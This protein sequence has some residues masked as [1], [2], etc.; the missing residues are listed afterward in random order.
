MHYIQ[1]S[2]V[3][4]EICTDGQCMNAGLRQWLMYECRNAAVLEWLKFCTQ[5][6]FPSQLSTNKNLMRCWCHC[7]RIEFSKA[8]VKN[9]S[10]WQRINCLFWLCSISSLAWW[11]ACV[12]GGTL[13]VTVQRR[14]SACCSIILLHSA[15]SSSKLPP[16]NFSMSDMISPWFVAIATWLNAQQMHYVWDYKC[17]SDLEVLKNGTQNFFLI[18]GKRFNI[19]KHAEFL[20]PDSCATTNALAHKATTLPMKF[21]PKVIVLMQERSSAWMQQI[22]HTMLASISLVFGINMFSVLFITKMCECRNAGW[23]LYL[24]VIWQTVA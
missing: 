17:S 1:S 5:C 2:K 9:S 22:L 4:Y 7:R 21:A 24:N 11:F 14:T 19:W 15:S 13:L 6:L 12:E 23:K 10:S 18:F 8:S 16:R 3:S 20:K